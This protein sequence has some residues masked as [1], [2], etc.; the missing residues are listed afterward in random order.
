MIINH[1]CYENNWA[2]P[3]DI[4][5]AKTFILGSFNPHNPLQ[6]DTDYY[7]GRPLNYFWKV[8]A[9]LLGENDN[10]FTDNIQ[11]KL[12]VMDDY[13]FCFLDVISSI[14][15]TSPDNNEVNVQQF[16]NDHIF[17]NFFDSKLFTTNHNHEGVVLNRTYNQ[18]VIDTINNLNIERAIHTMGNTRISPN[19]ITSP[20]ENG[21]G[22][23]GF[24]GYINSILNLDVEFIPTSFSPS[25]YAVRRGGEQQLLNLKNWISQNLGINQL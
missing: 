14:E 1:A 7:Y 16:A 25:A 22:H 10:F 8:V 24:Q 6:G 5:G 18:Y 20:L 2:R 9:S 11:R 23:L 17:T 21:L 13:K 19:F 3:E 15:I 4:N 12:T